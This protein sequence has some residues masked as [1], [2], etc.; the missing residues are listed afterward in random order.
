MRKPAK[1]N[2][3]AHKAYRPIALFNTIG[4][5][6]DAV[7]ASRLSYLIEIPEVLP[8]THIGDRKL[9]STENA[10]HAISAKIYESWNTRKDGQMAS[11]LL[12]D[13]SGAFD[14]VSHK[15]LLHNLWKRKADEKS[16]R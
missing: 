5:S 8:P 11:L 9:R 13:V 4:K 14:N 16:V 3:T 15:R 6:M 1:T 12:L 10:L 7:I 2:Y